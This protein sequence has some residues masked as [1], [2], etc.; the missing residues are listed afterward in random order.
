M[1]TIRI[2]ESTEKQLAR[3]CEDEG[4]TKSA[5]V[6]EA[7]A[8]YLSQKR[9]AKNAYSA[10]ADLFGQEGSGS[11]DLSVAYKQKLKKKL[12]AKHAH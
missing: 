5:V 7:L 12:H 2:P 11:S 8:L 10:G 4:I 1:L 9:T 3:Y 6:K